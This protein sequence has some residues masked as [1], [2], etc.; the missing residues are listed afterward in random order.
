VD[1]EPF[2]DA[3]VAA[4]RRRCAWVDPA[5]QLWN[6]SLLENLLYGATAG[7]RG[8]L[9]GSLQDADLWGVVEGLPEGLESPLGEG[10][11]FLSGGEG[12]RVRLARA[13]V[14]SDGGLVILDEPF[15]GLDRGQRARLLTRALERWRGATLLCVTHDVGETRAFPRVVVVEGGR[16]VEDGAPADL[17]ARSGT[18]YRSLLE[19]EGDVRDRLWGSSVWRHVVLADGRVTAAGEGR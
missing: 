12:Q 16:I 6:R 5:V 15:R 17:L 9:Q 3:A 14:R 10:G 18:W 2:D 4:L 1:G 7:Q 19:A 11:G 13:L 8:D